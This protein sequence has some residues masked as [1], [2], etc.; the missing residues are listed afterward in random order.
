MK[1]T[2]LSIAA[3]LWILASCTKGF[4]PAAGREAVVHVHAV[5]SSRDEASKGPVYGTSFGD[6]E[7]YGIFVSRSGSTTDAHKANSWNIK[8]VYSSG[9]AAW[10]YY[11]V[12]ETAT[13]KVSA[14]GYGN[15][16]VTERPDAE[17]ADL[18]AYAPYSQAAYLS[19]PEAIPYDVSAQ[20]DLMYAVENTS[21][22]NQG[23]DPDSP[24]EL[25]ASFTFRHAYALLAFKF[26]L[27][28]DAPALFNGVTV[29]LAEGAGTARLYR[30]GTFNATTGTFND[31]GVEV[32]SLDI[33]S[34]FGFRK[35]N[36]AYAGILL[37]PTD[38]ADGELVFRIRINGQPTQPF[39]LK[40]SYLLHDDGVTYGF[41]PGYRYTFHFTIDNYVCFDG[42]SISE[43]WDDAVLGEEEI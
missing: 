10:T 17:T 27:A 32:S 13:G 5:I 26:D 4:A 31:D 11:Y 21:S 25:E 24:E 23:L 15:V 30:S 18:Y 29:S 14:A 43:G 39:V 8:A 22:A 35:Q 12:D 16:T 40:R 38:V 6:R 1:R 37:R 28:H 20:T 34:S 19:G 7:T 42:F 9:S 33:N 41:Q 2:V 3:V 36:E